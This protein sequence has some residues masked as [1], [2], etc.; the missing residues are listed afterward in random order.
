MA[1]CRVPPVSHALGTPVA[2]TLRW[3]VTGS[4]GQ[5]L[6]T[7]QL[8]FEKEGFAKSISALEGG[9]PAG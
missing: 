7:R 3:I 5:V 2:E 8:R 4:T 6:L 1:R 9:A